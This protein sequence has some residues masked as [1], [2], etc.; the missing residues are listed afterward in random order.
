ML[1]VLRNWS[2]KVGQVICSGPKLWKIYVKQFKK[3][4]LKRQAKVQRNSFSFTDGAGPRG[5]SLERENCR[6]FGEGKE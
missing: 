3:V 4:L 5:G 2:L 6:Q 1:G